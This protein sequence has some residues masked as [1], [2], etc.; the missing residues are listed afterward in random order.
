MWHWPEGGAGSVPGGRGQ[1]DLPKCPSGGRGWQLPG[2]AWPEPAREASRAGAGSFSGLWPP[3][4]GVLCDL[5]SHP[6]PAW[7]PHSPTFSIPRNRAQAQEPLKTFLVAT[8]KTVFETGGINFNNVILFNPID[9]KYYQFNHAI[10][11]KLSHE[12]FDTVFR[13]GS[14]KSGVSSP[15]LRG[16]D[17]SGDRRLRAVSGCWTTRLGAA[18]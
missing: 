9:P 1:R 6:P 8:L 4:F 13:S 15:S 7:A 14:R 11:V 18:L 10:R 16:S 5:T 2:W 17:T 12:T 3:P